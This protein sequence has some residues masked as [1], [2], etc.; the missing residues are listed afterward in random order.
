MKK[1]YLNP[2]VDCV[3]FEPNQS[4]LMGESGA[5]DLGDGFAPIRKM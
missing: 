5:T 3:F 4:V 1:E 2:N